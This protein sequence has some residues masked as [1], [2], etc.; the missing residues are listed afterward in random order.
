MSRISNNSFKVNSALEQIVQVS[1]GTITPSG[2]QNVD[3]VGNTIGLATESTLSNVSSELAT[4]STDL[5]NISSNTSSTSSSCS[6]IDSNTSNISS[7]TATIA[8]N[9]TTISGKITQGYDATITSGGSGLQQVV[10]Y[11]RDSGGNLDACT[12]N[13]SG[14]LVVTTSGGSGTHSGSQANLMNAVSATNGTT[15]NVITT[16]SSNNVN[17][18]GNT[19]GTGG[20]TV[21]QSVD[22]SNFY[23]VGYSAFPNTSGDFA[24]SFAGQPANYWRIKATETA[25][26]TASLVHS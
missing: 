8:S 5:N 12:I 23:D 7:D 2:T 17:I 4:Q 25:T 22:N 3:V 15:S 19:T 21:Q 9:T 1:G 16:T 14:E 18:F 13:G 6:N 26:I 20:I 24:V 10:I 11:G